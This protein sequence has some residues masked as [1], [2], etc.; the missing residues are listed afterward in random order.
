MMYFHNKNIKQDIAVIK[1]KVAEKWTLRTIILNNNEENKAEVIVYNKI[2][3]GK[4]SNCNE[5][6]IVTSINYPTEHVKYIH[7]ALND[8]CVIVAGDKKSIL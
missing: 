2:E 4:L 8:W 5:W 1:S 7:N 3:H 6:I